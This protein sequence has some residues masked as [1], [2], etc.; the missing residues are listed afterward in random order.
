M[1]LPPWLVLALVAS[2]V[3]ALMYQILS[4]RFGWRVIG[5]WIV[6]SLGVL[7]GEALAESL[8][9]N[10]MR[11]GDLRILPDLAGAFAVVA[12]LWFLGI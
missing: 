7:A 10:A 5:Y 12:I 3:I 9:W 6:I 8:G 4:R 11:I 2:L 1:T